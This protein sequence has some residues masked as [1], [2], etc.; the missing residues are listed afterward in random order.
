MKKLQNCLYINRDGAYLHKE[1]ETLLIEQRIDGKKQKLMQ[2]PIHSIGHIFCFGNVMV[3]PQVMGFCG[4]NATGLAFFNQYGRFQARVV[5]KQSGNVLLRR[6]QYR[7]SDEQA[8]VLARNIVAAKVRSSRQVL[9][10]HTRNHQSTPEMECAIQRHRQIVEALSAQQDLE[11]IRGLEGEAASH[12]FS[13]FGSLITNTDKAFSFENRNRRP[14][15][16]PVNAMLSFLYAVLGNE[17][18]SALQGVGL[19]PQA[20]FLHAE[21]PG[22]DSLAQDLLEEFRALIVDRLVL[23]LIN[24]NQVGSKDFEVDA[25]GGVTIKEDARKAVLQAY[26]LKKQE[27]IIHPFL[28]EKVAI[29]LLP[30]VQSMLLARY[31]RGDL[32]NYPPYYSR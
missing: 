8:V 5:G 7:I 24:R 13:V 3:S 6:Q 16:D 26:Q 2:L 27:E 22:R 31:I 19:D 10:R 28:N 14:P 17:I 21:R 30:H 15:K 25:L 4:E 23:T 11:K 29:G 12:Y 18:S 20:G 32:D 9:Q 1:R